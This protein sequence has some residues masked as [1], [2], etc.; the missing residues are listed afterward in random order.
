MEN[1]KQIR[2]EWVPLAYQDKVEEATAK[3]TIVKADVGNG[4]A[5][6]GMKKGQKKHLG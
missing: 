5:K 1:L 6:K 4:F 3:Q 2:P